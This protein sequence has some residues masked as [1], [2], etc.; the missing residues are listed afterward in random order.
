[1]FRIFESLDLYIYVSIIISII[2]LSLLSTLSIRSKN[3]FLT[4]LWSYVSVILSDNYSLKY[5]AKS[6]RFLI[7]VWLMSCTVLLAAISGIFREFLIKAKPIY[8]IDTWKDLA[9]WNLLNVGVT[10]VIY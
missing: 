9:E 1:M 2:V 5:N 10:K 7:G 4:V 8:Y 3:K 6:D